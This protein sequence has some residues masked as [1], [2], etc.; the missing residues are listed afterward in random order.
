MLEKFFNKYPYMIWV[1]VTI[2]FIVA[3]LLESLI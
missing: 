1:F 3:S 2:L